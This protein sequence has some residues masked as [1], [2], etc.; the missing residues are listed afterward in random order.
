[1]TLRTLGDTKGAIECQERALEIDETTFGKSHF[2]LVMPL[3]QFAGLVEEA[4][5]AAAAEPHWRRAVQ[6]AEGA[7]DSSDPELGAAFVGLASVCRE[8]G[9]DAEAKSC[10]ER[11]LATLP[12]DPSNPHPLP[13]AIREL[14][15]RVLQPAVLRE[16][17]S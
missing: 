3:A 9:K 2:E 13:R 6:C 15:Q 12:D 1:S 7:L 4:R 14:A 16:K 10:A 5:G 17:E 11:A 8:I